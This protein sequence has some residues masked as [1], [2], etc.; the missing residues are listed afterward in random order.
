MKIILAIFMF[1]TAWIGFSYCFGWRNF[2]EEKENERK[3]RVDKY[4]IVLIV[5]S[6]IA[7]ICGLGYI[8]W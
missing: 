8:F 4:G 1:Y 2:S 3:K 5:F 6:T 7:L